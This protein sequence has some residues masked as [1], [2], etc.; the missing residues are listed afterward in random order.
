LFAISSDVNAVPTPAELS[1]LQRLCLF[2]AGALR[3]GVACLPSAPEWPS[4]A[5]LLRAKHALARRRFAA[6]AEP[7]FAGVP[8][9]GV[10]GAGASRGAR[11]KPIGR[12]AARALALLPDRLFREVLPDEAQVYAG[13]LRDLM[14]DEDMLALLAASPLARRRLVPLWRM[15]TAEPLPDCARIVQPPRRPV[16]P[17]RVDR[18]GRP[19]RSGGSIHSGRATPI[20]AALGE[21]PSAVA[22]RPT[23]P[24]PVLAAPWPAMARAAGASIAPISRSSGLPSARTPRIADWPAWPERCRQCAPRPA[25]ARDAAARRFI[26]PNSLRYKHGC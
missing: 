7:F 20:R 18:P 11:A 10:P 3:S 9:A 5:A 15:M 25:P 19:G 12:A 4:L 22:A 14:H 21:A 2:L 17:G 6:V 26:T 13:Y 1:L 23:G 24:L 16:R 8:A